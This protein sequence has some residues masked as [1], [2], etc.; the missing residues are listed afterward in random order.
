MSKMTSLYFT[1]PCWLPLVSAVLSP[2]VE[3]G[4]VV[5]RWRASGEEMVV[6]GLYE[7]MQARA[8]LNTHTP[9]T[10]DT[11]YQREAVARLHLPFPL[12]SDAAFQLTSALNLPT[13]EVEGMRLIKRLVLVIDEG[14]IA[15]V[16]YPIF[17][18]D[19][20]AA[21]V[22]AWLAASR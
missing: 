19:Q 5:D 15:R 17:P 13:F 9:S 7:R 14:G 12:L 20:S 22:L 11:A 8:I 21:E 16:F 6:A 18:P 4:M 1:A 2:F 3:V 10:Q